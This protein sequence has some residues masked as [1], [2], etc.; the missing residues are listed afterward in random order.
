MRWRQKAIVQQVISRL[1]ASDAIYYALQRSV[2]DLRNGR[3]DPMEWVIV[4]AEMAGRLRQ[5]GFALAGKR[6]LEIG[7]GR[8]IGLPLCL[9]LCGAEQVVT[10]DLNKYLSS[11]LVQQSCQSLARNRERVESMLRPAAEGGGLRERLDQL[12]RFR[13]GTASLLKLINVVYLAPG[14]ATRLPFPDQSFDLHCSYSVL[15]HMPG[16]T[17][18]AM[19]AEARRLLRFGGVLFHIFDLSDH[20]SYVD[21]SIT[22]INFLRFSDA[23]WNRWAGNKYM[24]HNRLR[25]FEF[26]K[27]FQDAGVRINRQSRGIDERSLRALQAG[28][29]IHERFRSLPQEELA[30]GAMQIMGAFG[31]DA[32][33]VNPSPEINCHK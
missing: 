28:F 4:A 26:V 23:Q 17:I 30:V 21:N 20:F 18:A 6:C 15:E 25:P 11:K 19:L 1:P 8:A 33:D 2:G 31:P 24:Y 9:W 29:P 22:K 3:F 13:G 12:C 32:G 16:P 7:T 10:V 5:S 27:L 14:D